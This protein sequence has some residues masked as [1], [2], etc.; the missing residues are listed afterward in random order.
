MGTDAYPSAGRPGRT[1]ASLQPL[2]QLSSVRDCGVILIFAVRSRRAPGTV[3]DGSFA[4]L[5]PQTLL[6]QSS[7][8]RRG[9]I[10]GDTLRGQRTDVV[11][12]VLLVV[13]VVQVEVVLEDWHSDR[14]RLEPQLG[15]GPTQ[16][17]KPAGDHEQTEVGCGLLTVG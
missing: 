1:L 6:G 3:R 13:A 12:G 2:D 11:V 9:W 15:C 7:E 16:V 17:S 5:G 4:E 10:D 8:L 14:D